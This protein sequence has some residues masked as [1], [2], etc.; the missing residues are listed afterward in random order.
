[1][2]NGALIGPNWV[3]ASLQCLEPHTSFGRINETHEAT[4]HLKGTLIVPR[5]WVIKLGKSKELARFEPNEQVYSILHVHALKGDQS[6]PDWDR[7]LLIEI[8]SIASVTPGVLPIC[9]ADRRVPIQNATV[10][11]WRAATRRHKYKFF[12]SNF[13]EAPEC[14]PENSKRDYMCT[15]KN[16]GKHVRYAITHNLGAPLVTKVADSWFVVGI[17]TDSTA[18][19]T[20]FIDVRPFYRWIMWKMGLLWLVTF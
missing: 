13:T 14:L 18:E 11:G 12:S 20:K 19:E 8:S 10:T 15:E 2:C 17:V 3:L 1:M 9:P 4:G 16:D 6:H 5:H 7:L